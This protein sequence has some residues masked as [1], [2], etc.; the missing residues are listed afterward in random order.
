M[1]HPRRILPGQ[2]Y[3]I[4]RRCCQR[5][6]RLLPSTLTNA[7]FGYRL[8]LAMER[9]GVQVHAACV[10]SNHH[11]LVVTDPRG[12]LP[13]FLREFHRLTAKAL[14]AAHGQRENLWA[15]QAA[16]IVRL[17]TDD[18]VDDK[19]A[20]VAVNP[21]AA[22][23][24]ESPESWPGFHAWVDEQRS[25]IRPK[26]YFSDDGI[27]PAELLL[28]VQPPP[29]RDHKG[30]SRSDWI[31]NIEQKIVEAAGEAR[32]AIRAESR[33]FLGAAAVLETSF[34]RTAFK[35]EARR[36][37]VPTFAGRVPAVREEL[38]A[39]EKGFRAQYRNALRLWRSGARD[40]TF[41]AGTWWM[42]MFHRATVEPLLA[43]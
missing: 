26:V 31:R 17:V 41:P 2:T 14:N 4:T 8:A 39:V 9:S 34:A 30:R 15:A 42:G 43:A 3:L 12:R 37:V 22:G 32:A 36:E 10:M 40:V 29:N 19:I 5:A 24:V 25:V 13:I 33:T 1:A 27:C 23:L 35:F 20:Y 38:R 18:D 7:V 21:V 11:H 16:N 6:F 28:V